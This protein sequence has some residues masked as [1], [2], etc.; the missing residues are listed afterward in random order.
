MSQTRRPSI[1]SSRTTPVAI[2]IEF[3][4]LSL[5]NTAPIIELQERS[6]KAQINPVRKLGWGFD[7]ALAII[8]TPPKKAGLFF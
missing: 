1:T 7:L 2:R 5:K 3:I 8:F 6:V 4:L